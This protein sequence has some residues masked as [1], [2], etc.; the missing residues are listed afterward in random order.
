MRLR[1][2]FAGAKTVAWLATNVNRAQQEIGPLLSEWRYVVDAVGGRSPLRWEVPAE[3]EEILNQRRR[4]ATAVTCGG[5]R[6]ARKPDVQQL[7]D[8]AVAQTIDAAYAIRVDL[9]PAELISAT[10]RFPGDLRAAL[11]RARWGSLAFAALTSG[12]E[13]KGDALFVQFEPPVI[14]CAMR[15]RRGVA[16]RTTLLIGRD[17]RVDGMAVHKTWSE[18]FKRRPG[19][20]AGWSVDVPA[21]PPPRDLETAEFGVAQKDRRSIRQESKRRFFTGGLER[22]V[23]AKFRSPPGM[24]WARAADLAYTV[25]HTRDDR[26]VWSIDTL[27]RRAFVWTNRLPG[28]RPSALIGVDGLTGVIDSLRVGEL[29]Q[30]AVS[31]GTFLNSQPIELS[32]E[33]PRR[34]ALKPPRTR[35]WDRR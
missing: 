3:R 2:R 4:P 33:P 35:S 14:T 11:T 5:N 27:S 26:T 21:V 1:F 32:R 30:F 34:L 13:R 15:P 9:G 17:G 20:L 31:F 23:S 8:D 19:L 28:D 18:L 24:S 10:A 25:L 12:S 6:I 7:V 16:N 22:A 29:D